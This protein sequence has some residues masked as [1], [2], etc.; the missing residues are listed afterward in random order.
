[1][2]TCED[3]KH[4][5][6]EANF[7][8][9]IALLN[10]G[11]RLVLK[12]T[13]KKEVPG[14]NIIG[15]LKPK[16]EEV[17][18]KYVKGVKG[19]KQILYQFDKLYPKNGETDPDKYDITLLTFLLRNLSNLDSKLDVWSKDT[20]PSHD[21]TKPAD[22][23]RLRLWRNKIA[24]AETSELADDEFEKRWNELKNVLLNLGKDLIPNL[25]RKISAM[26]TETIDPKREEELQ[27][28]IDTWKEKYIGLAD[29]IHLLKQSQ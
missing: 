6:E 3:L 18:K 24:H 28:V 1:M 7:F 8:R 9:Y 22:I 2:A 17:R 11:G 29:D 15:Y 20:V 5:K 19:S 12:E 13:Y 25:E 26:K 16:Q 14:G 10:D 4:S 21:T 27:Q 23:T